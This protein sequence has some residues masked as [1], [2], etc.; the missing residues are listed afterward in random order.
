MKYVELLR[1]RP[2]AIQTDKAN[3]QHYEVGT[4]V[5]ECCLGPRMKVRG[6]LRPHKPLHLA[7]GTVTFVSTKNV[8]CALTRFGLSSTHAAGTKPERRH[9]AKPR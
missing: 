7:G 5:L 4:G 8:C 3:E 6:I 2:I 9:S 1:S